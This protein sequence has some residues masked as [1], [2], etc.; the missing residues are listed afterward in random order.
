MLKEIIERK[1]VVPGLYLSLVRRL[2]LKSIFVGIVND[3]LKH[4]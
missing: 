2:V 1:K 4:S 3:S